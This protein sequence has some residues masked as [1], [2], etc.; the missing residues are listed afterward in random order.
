MGRRDR[1]ASAEKPD[2]QLRAGVGASARCIW[3]RP[4]WRSA[5]VAL[6]GP[7]WRRE[8]PPFVEDK[9]PLMIA[10]AVSSS[11][12]RTDVAP[13]R[14]ERGQAENQGSADCARGRPKR[15]GRL[16]RHRA[17]G[18]AADRRPGRDR[19]VPR[20]ARTRFDAGRR[21]ECHRRGCACGQ[22]ARDRTGCR[23]DFAGR[24]RSRRRRRRDAAPGCR[25]QQHRDAGRVS[26]AR[27]QRCGGARCGPRHHRWRRRQGARAPYRDPV[28]GRAGRRVRHAMARRRFLAAVAGRAAQP[29]LVSARHDGGVG[30]CS[31]HTAGMAGGRAGSVALRRSGG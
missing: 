3:W 31:L 21:E 26:A 25:T 7:T 15:A 8:L 6:S 23:H 16:C 29:A 10:L 27:R 24:G 20:R 13:S 5:I 12:G 9:A 14:L 28:P 18:D 11:M 30:C 2:R 17:S 1:A 19:T 22:V 4:A